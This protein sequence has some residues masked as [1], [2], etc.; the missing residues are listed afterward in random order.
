MKALALILRAICGCA[1]ADLAYAQEWSKAPAPLNH[2]W[3]AIASSAD[4]TKLVAADAVRGQIC[5]STNSGATWDLAS[6]PGHSWSCVG[7]SAD[8][9][10]LVAAAGNL[11]EGTSGPIYRS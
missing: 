11:E 5:T 7:S 3:N 10:K 1:F 2:F 9:T 8:G 4:G 6:A